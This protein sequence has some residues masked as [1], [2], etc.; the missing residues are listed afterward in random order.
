MVAEDLRIEL[1]EAGAKVLGP[2]PSVAR[3]LALL[4][5]EAA[6]DAAV[7]DVNLG[8][9]M[10]FPLAEVLRERGIPFMF[11][12]G[13][14]RRELPLAYADTPRCEKPFVVAKC[15]QHL[16]GSVATTA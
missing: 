1:E 6:P 9:Q 12:T 13:Y 11:A 2:V 15:L 14:D 8:G 16:F 5:R 7:L 4:A 3:A 10:V